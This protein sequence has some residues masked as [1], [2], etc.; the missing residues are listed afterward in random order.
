MEFIPEDWRNI[1]EG[2][3]FI[4]GNGPS[5]VAQLPLLEQLKDKATMTCNGMTNWGDLPFVPTYHASTDVPLRKW[6]D[7][8]EGAHWTSTYRFVCQ[9]AGEEPHPSFYIVPTEPDSIQSFS[10]GM[11]GMGKDWEDIRTAR[12]TP[13]TIAQLAWWMG[14]RDIYYL[15]IEQTRGYAWNPEQTMSVNKRGEFPLDKHIRYTWAIQRSAAR[16]RQEIEEAGGHIY[17]CTPNG[18]LTG[19]SDVQRRGMSGPQ[20]ILEYRE[21]S[22]VLDGVLE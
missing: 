4:L 13:L 14:Y 8:I 3:I 2:R 20:H 15:G 17:D 6:L 5:L 7:L 18:L 11:A 16:M 1:A 19:R 9:R 10:H 21:L 12:T 22:E